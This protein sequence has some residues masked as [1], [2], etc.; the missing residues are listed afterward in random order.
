MATFAYNEYT[1][2][3]LTLSAAAASILLL[4]ILIAVFVYLRIVGVKDVV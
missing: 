2:V 1:N 3:H 4:M